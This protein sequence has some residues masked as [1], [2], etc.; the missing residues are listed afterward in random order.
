MMTFKSRDSG[1]AVVFIVNRIS[2]AKMG[3][4]VSYHILGSGNNK[5]FCVSFEEGA[6]DLCTKINL[7]TSL[8]FLIPFLDCQ[9][10]HVTPLFIYPHVIKF[11]L[12]RMLININKIIHWKFLE[13]SKIWFL[14]YIC[15][16]R[17][18][19]YWIPWI[20]LIIIISVYPYCIG[21]KCTIY[22]CRSAYSSSVFMK[23]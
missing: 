17:D 13:V 8:D 19:I 14:A 2:M 10:L 1:T 23:T 9:S 12:I 5:N 15:K 18:T 21:N 20:H 7:L 16:F 3:S 22:S 11:P 4:I 6:Y